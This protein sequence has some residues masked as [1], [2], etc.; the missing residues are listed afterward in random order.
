M[1]MEKKEETKIDKLVSEKG[2]FVKK[3]I[4]RWF[5]NIPKDKLDKP[6]V[7]SLGMDSKIL[8]PRDL[9]KDLTHQVTKKSISKDK[10][11]LLKEII[12]KYGEEKK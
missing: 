8:T 10:M 11:S 9:Y 1:N 3:A 4:D 2:D 7:A 6:I 5:E 12:A